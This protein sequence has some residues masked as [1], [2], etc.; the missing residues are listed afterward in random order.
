MKDLK[1]FSG[2]TSI[3]LVDKHRNTVTDLRDKIYQVNLSK[4]VTNDRFYL[5]FGNEKL[6]LTE[7]VLEPFILKS[8]EGSIGVRMNLHVGK[9]VL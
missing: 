1:N 5:S 6:Q 3:Y 9:K 8:D 4:G 7:L 2:Q